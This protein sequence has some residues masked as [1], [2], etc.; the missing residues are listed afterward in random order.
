MASMAH[1]RRYVNAALLGNPM[2]SRVF[3]PERIEAYCHQSNYRWRD[4]F[5]SPALTLLSF[6]LQVS[7]AEK[8]LRAGVAALLSQLKLRGEEDL[9]S[10]DP[11][12]WCAATKPSTASWTSIDSW[13]STSNAT[14]RNARRCHQCRTTWSRHCSIGSSTLSVPRIA[15]GPTSGS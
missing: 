5:W 12:A 1:W 11:T 4:S 15:S 10:A 2:V 7:S 9:P 3:S 14:P 13:R 8:T 6:V